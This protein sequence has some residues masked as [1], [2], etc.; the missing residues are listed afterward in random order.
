MGAG[1]PASAGGTLIPALDQANVQAG[2]DFSTPSIRITVS[3]NL[4]HDPALG[5]TPDGGLTLQADSLTTA[6]SLTLSGANTFT[7]DTNVTN[8]TASLHGLLILG[9]TLA[10]ARKHS[11]YDVR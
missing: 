4:R 1:N 3:Q 11:E 6:G 10:L 8:N 5:A 9:S 2:G 7:G